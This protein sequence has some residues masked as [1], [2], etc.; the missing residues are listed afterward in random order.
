MHICW[1][2]CGLRCEDR[3]SS[4]IVCTTAAWYSH[5]QAST[6]R[7]HDAPCA[8]ASPLLPPLQAA[9]RG[10]PGGAGRAVSA[11]NSTFPDIRL[12]LEVP[13]RLWPK[14]PSPA[15]VPH[16][17]RSAMRA[18]ALIALV[19]CTNRIRSCSPCAACAGEALPRLV[20]HYASSEPRCPP[21]FVGCRSSWAWLQRASLPA[22]QAP[23]PGEPSATRRYAAAGMCPVLCWACPAWQFYLQVPA[24]HPPSLPG[25]PDSTACRR[26]RLSG[27]ETSAQ[28]PARNMTKRGILDCMFEDLENLGTVRWA[29][30]C[31]SPPH[32]TFSSRFQ[33]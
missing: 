7:Q 8:C 3:V 26:R 22:R 10:V 28:A 6:P 5:R 11:L 1:A 25:P 29:H 31:T 23:P 32:D 2:L 15:Q 20:A 19:G 17:A 24:P 30:R 4:N 12:H 21:N 18:I 9:Q 14:H 13:A 27:I 16:A 33:T